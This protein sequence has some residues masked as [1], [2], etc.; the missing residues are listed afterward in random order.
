MHCTAVREEG[1]VPYW[2]INFIQNFAKQ[3]PKKQEQSFSKPTSLTVSLK[4]K[5]QKVPVSILDKPLP[6]SRQE[7]LKSLSITFLYHILSTV[8]NMRHT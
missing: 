5:P 8:L 1:T 3:L 7:I 6:F 4:T 2:I